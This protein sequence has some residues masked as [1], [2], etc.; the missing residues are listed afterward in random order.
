[1]EYLLYVNKNPEKQL[2]GVILIHHKV[3]VKH[4]FF[5]CGGG[6]GVRGRWED[7]REWGWER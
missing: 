6:E 5:F 1:V 3:Y 2:F 7:E 4:L